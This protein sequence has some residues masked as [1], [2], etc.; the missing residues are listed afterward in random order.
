MKKTYIATIAATAM[1]LA[2]TLSSC[3]SEEP[4]GL[5][6]PMKWKTEVKVV[7]E[8]GQTFTEV[9]AKGGTYEY[10]CKNYNRMWFYHVVEAK[11]FN[12]Y[13]TPDAKVYENTDHLKRFDCPAASVDIDGPHLAVTIKP[14]TTG[15]R[16]FIEIDVSVGDTGKTFRYRQN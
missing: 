3:S 15:Q 6:D 5:W 10:T 12:G 9:P 4:D 2:A 16:R 14:N 13:N 7:K 1:L 11:Q 8:D